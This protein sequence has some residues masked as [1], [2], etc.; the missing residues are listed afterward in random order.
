MIDKR[1]RVVIALADRFGWLNWADRDVINAVLD[2]AP[3]TLRLKVAQR[4]G[5]RA[6]SSRV[7]GT[8]PQKSER[9]PDDSCDGCLNL[10]FQIRQQFSEE[11]L[12]QE[13]PGPVFAE[14]PEAFVS[15]IESSLQS[16]ERR[17]VT[18]SALIAA[19]GREARVWI[20]YGFLGQQSRKSK[21]LLPS[22]VRLWNA[23]IALED[24]SRDKLNFHQIL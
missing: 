16:I 20:A 15:W 6:R 9:V 12:R 2:N 11:E 23:T 14:Q 7:S 1:K 3:S 10:D 18:D 22:L 5:P 17:R 4:I 8:E 13:Q 21:R 24:E 19:L